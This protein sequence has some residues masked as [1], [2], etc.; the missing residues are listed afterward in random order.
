MRVVHHP[1]EQLYLLSDA[2]PEG[3]LLCDGSTISIMEYHELYDVLGNI[4]GTGDDSYTLEWVDENNDGMMQP[5]EMIE[6]P[7]TFSLPDLRGRVPVGLDNMGGVSA[8]VVDEASFLGFSSGE[9]MHKLTEDEM[10]IHDHD[11]QL[12]SG[13]STSGGA[14]GIQF[15]SQPYTFEINKII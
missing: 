14:P 9:K 2:V 7:S 10:P 1:Q 8:Q 6:V 3:W 4:Y 11:L 5:E 13:Y 12:C 15:Y